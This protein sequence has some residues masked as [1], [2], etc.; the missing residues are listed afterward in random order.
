MPYVESQHLINIPSKG[1]L[2]NWVAAL[3]EVRFLTPWELLE[4]HTALHAQY[5]AEPEGA[6]ITG[7]QEASRMLRHLGIEHRYKDELSIAAGTL[8]ES[9]VQPT[10][11]EVGLYLK[12]M[13]AQSNMVQLISGVAKDG[14]IFLRVDNSVIPVSLNKAILKSVNRMMPPGVRLRVLPGTAQDE[15]ARVV[16]AYD[17]QL[18]A[19]HGRVEIQPWKNLLA[20]A[21]ESILKSMDAKGNIQ[22]DAQIVGHEENIIINKM[23]EDDDG[24]TEHFVLAAVLVPESEDAHGEIYSKTEVRKACHWWAENSGAFS[25]RHVM[26]GGRACKPN[27]VVL[28]ENWCQRGDTEIGGELIKDGTWMLGSGVRNAEIWRDI[29]DKK[30]NAY[31]IGAE[32]SVYEEVVPA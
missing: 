11:E 8:V 19:A 9:P 12:T 17:L 30:I 2:A 29:V 28:L 23:I 13:T 27:E 10:L 32:A 25:H 21:P 6:L 24:E 31:S 15:F 14:A 7:E 5:G 4:L 16:P 20:T 26:Q 1:D 22:L 18:V 3:E